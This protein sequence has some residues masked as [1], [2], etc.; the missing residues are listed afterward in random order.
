[1]IALKVIFPFLYLTSLCP[2]PYSSGLICSEGPLWRDQ[3]RHTIDWLKGLGMT[4]KFGDI[5]CGLEQRIAKGV[6]EC[7]QVRRDV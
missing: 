5:R 2:F 7:I 6:Q 1:M 4:K 3:R